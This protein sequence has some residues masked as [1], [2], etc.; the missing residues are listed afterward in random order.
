[1]GSRLISS[2]LIPCIHPVINIIQKAD[3]VILVLLKK[4]RIKPAKKAVV[5]NSILAV[6]SLLHFF[7]NQEAA[8]MLKML[9]NGK[10]T[11]VKMDTLVWR[12]KCSEIKVGIQVMI[13]SRNI[14]WQIIANII[15]ID[16]ESSIIDHRDCCVTF[17]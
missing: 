10:N 7:C 4:N 6:I 2:I 1:M 17:F 15:G 16:P 12:A 14:P 3:I 5:N 13:P 9:N 8:E 11:V